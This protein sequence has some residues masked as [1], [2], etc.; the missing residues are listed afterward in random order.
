[1][2]NPFIEK[3]TNVKPALNMGLTLGKTDT[4]GKVGIE[5]E[6]EG[7]KFPFP[8]GYKETHT[9]VK[10][11]GLKYWSYVHDGS[12]RGQNSAEYLLTKPIE[13]SEVNKA[14]EELYKK[15]EEYGTIIDESNRTSTHVH[16][17]CQELFLNQL[18][19]FMA[20]WFT[21]EE[22]LTQWCGEHRV[23]NLFCLRSRD[24][25]A[26]ISHLRKFIK[27]DGKYDFNEGMHYAG[28]NASALK[29][30]GSIEIRTMRGVSDPK[31]I[32]E[33]VEILQRL[34]NLSLTY[35]DPRDVCGLFSGNG[36]M[37]FF[38]SML[39]DKAAVVR[40]GINFSDERIRDSMYEG[41]RLAQDLCYC[42]DWDLFKT[43]ELKE[44]PFGRD[45]KAVAQQILN[46]SVN[47]SSYDWEGQSMP[48]SLEH[49]NQMYTQ[50]LHVAS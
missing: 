11:A 1:M 43:V 3:P 41:I 29:K 18:T 38:N 44:N 26:I 48:S 9:P 5:I 21:F 23:G 22:V 28:L 6:M 36:P 10:V 37:H 15:L 17:N 2:P 39:G 20:L 47:T 40:A 25:T 16:L 27:S 13:F 33:W 34:Y 24:A 46:G 8:A 49:L 7:N 30:Y 32:Q 4:K 31:V 14:I 19:S 35:K 12:L 50:V 45:K 42:R